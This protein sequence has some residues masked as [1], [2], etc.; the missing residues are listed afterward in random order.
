M[1]RYLVS[2]SIRTLCFVLA[3]FLSGPARWTCV[4]LACVLPYVAVVMANAAR[5]RRVG[6]ITSVTP[7]PMRPQAALPHRDDPYV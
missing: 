6:T 2:M 7:P 3:I 5:V 4:L 1:R